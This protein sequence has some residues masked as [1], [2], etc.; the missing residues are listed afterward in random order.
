MNSIIDTLLVPLGT[1]LAGSFGG[2]FFGRKRQNIQNI[3][4]AL[5]TW[6]KVVDSLEDRVDKLLSEVEELTRQNCLLREEVDSL[7]DEIRISKRKNRQIT[8]LENKIQRY[9]KILDDNGI[10]Y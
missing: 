6:K 4:M 9:E 3:D 5:E 7:K 10:D 1:G 2:W 8:T